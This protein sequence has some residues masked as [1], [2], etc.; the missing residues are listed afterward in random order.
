MRANL[1][2]AK[3]S[4]ALVSI[5]AD[6]GVGGGA[7]DPR[8]C[9]RHREAARSTPSAQRRVRKQLPTA[10]AIRELVKPTHSAHRRDAKGQMALSL[11]RTP[12]SSSI[13]DAKDPTPSQELHSPK[14][15]SCLPP[16]STNTP[17]PWHFVD[18][19]RIA[20][21]RHAVID[22]ERTV[23]RGWRRV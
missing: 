17:A 21:P 12:T 3:G 5:C 11:P 16:T 4:R 2:M 1:A 22:V 6:S 14:P 20:S 9:P 23:V 15:L 18:R 7:S 19:A 10:L 8:Q 13:M